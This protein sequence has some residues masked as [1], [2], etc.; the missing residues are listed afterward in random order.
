VP[1]T[2]C[3]SETA[4]KEL[5]KKLEDTRNGMVTSPGLLLVMQTMSLG[6]SKAGTP[7]KQ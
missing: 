4:K 2:V 3:Y 5:G 1:I 7:E 6:A